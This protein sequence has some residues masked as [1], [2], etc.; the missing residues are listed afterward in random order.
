MEMKM[1]VL[2]DTNKKINDLKEF[3]IPVLLEVIKRYEESGV[4]E[5]F[6]KQQKVQ[7]DKVYVR[8]HELEAKAARLRQALELE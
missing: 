7:L 3:N 8:L 4:D 6:I 1:L 2:Q 5:L